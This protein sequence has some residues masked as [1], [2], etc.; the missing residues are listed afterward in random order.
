M[1]ETDEGHYGKSCQEVDYG[2][3]AVMLVSQLMACQ[4][5]VTTK[6]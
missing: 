4:Y 3:Q 2:L 6:E 5:S 1:Q